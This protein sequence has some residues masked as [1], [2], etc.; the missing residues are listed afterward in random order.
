VTGGTLRLAGAAGSINSTSSITLNGSGARLV[1]ASDASV[2][3]PV[4]VTNGAVAGS[5]TISSV[6]VANNPANVVSHGNGNSASLFI[7]NLAFQGAAQVT[8][9]DPAEGAQA[10]IVVTGSLSTT[11]A[12]GKVTINASRAFWPSG[13][14]YR[15]IDFASSSVA[16]S[17]F[18]VG[19]V[20]GLTNRQSATVV[21]SGSSVSLSIQG[22]TPRWTGAIS[23]VWDTATSGNWAL[24]LSGAPT[25]FVNGDLARF[26]DTATGTTVSIPAPGVSPSLTL[27]ENSSKSIT[28]TGAAGIAGSGGLTKNGSGTVTVGTVNSHT[29]GTL[30]NEGVLALTGAGTLGGASAAVTVAGG[31]LDLGGGSLAAGTVTL[32]GGGEVRNGTLAAVSLVGANT[33]GNSTVSAALSGPGAVLMNGVG[34]TVTLAAANGHTGGTTVSAGTLALSGAGALGGASANVVVTGG[35]LDL[36]GTTQNI[37][38]LVFSGPGEVRNGTLQAATV[39]ATNGTDTTAVLSAGLAGPG[40]LTKSGAG[41]LAV[42]GVHQHTG[43]T[44]INAGTLQLGRVVDSVNVG[45]SLPTT[46]P[47]T[48][49]SGATFA[50]RPEGTITQSASFGT[51]TGAGRVWVQPGGT[52]TFNVANTHTGTTDVN[53]RLLVTHPNAL[54]TGLVNVWDFDA[55]LQLEGNLTLNNQIQTGG[56]VV[57]QSLSGNNTLNGNITFV[58][59]GSLSTTISTSGGSTLTVNGNISATL[60]LARIYVLQGFGTTIVN[61]AITN[62]PTGVGNSVGITKNEGGQLHLRGVNTYTGRTIVNAGTLRVDGAIARNPNTNEATAIEI[63]E[64]G[65]L[66]GTGTIAGNLVVYGRLRPGAAGPAGGQLQLDSNYVELDYFSAETWFDFAGAAFTGVRTTV[67]G[68]FSY[69]GAL[70]LNFTGAVFNGSYKLFDIAGSPGGSFFEVSVQTPSG[71]GWLID[72]G[73]V[74]TGELDGVAYSFAPATGI[75]TVSGGATAITPDATMLEA[76][77]GNSSVDLSWTAASGADSYIIRR[78]IAPGGPYLVIAGAVPELFFTDISVVNDTTYYYT[79]QGRNGAS[80]LTGPVSNEVAATPEAPASSALESW[81]LINFGTTENS[82]NAADAADPDGDGYANLMEYALGSN[83]AIPNSGPLVHGELSEDG[84]RLQ[85]RFNAISD[86]NLV[87]TVQGASELSGVLAWSTVLSFNGSEAVSGE[88]AVPDTV[89]L[90]EAQKRFLRLVV[91]Y[92]AP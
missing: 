2:T 89:S 67:P 26:D 28:L 8:V 41:T 56:L 69:S 76:T 58:S 47:V 59:R 18:Q 27:F 6:T 31:A 11:P 50:I 54:S 53:G 25:I 73:G 87:Y 32:I 7:G 81:R 9:T 22:D 42:T 70:R 33:A 49:A 52:V 91:S 51:V 24:T 30:V 74:W 20:A 75:L 71:N 85:I 21:V 77:A 43:G 83:P 23:S 15:V 39:S 72:S 48:V 45:G 61:G 35:S 3:V 37:A 29:G 4:M 92:V 12:N 38:S 17:D 65:T 62:G 5:K 66:A 16:A 80:Q 44:T 68:A 55:R 34:G 64:A 1:Q 79:V 84:T 88:L 36:G 78:A 40:S 60:D 63:A 19:T 57:M 82:G 13:A 90:A 86:P 46:I 14:T 10:P